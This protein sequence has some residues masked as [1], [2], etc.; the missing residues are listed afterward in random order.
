M[1]SNQTIEMVTSFM[2]LCATISTTGSN[3]PQNYRKDYVTLRNDLISCFG[4]QLP[5]WIRTS[6]T[7][8]SVMAHVKQVKGTGNGSW[9]RRRDYFEEQRMIILEPHVSIQPIAPAS[10]TSKERSA[11]SLHSTTLHSHRHGGT[12]SM[13]TSLADFS[14]VSPRQ[15]DV[16]KMKM[17]QKVFIVHGHNSN[18]KLEVARLIDRA[19]FEAVI[20][21][22]HPNRGRTILQKLIELTDDVV[23]AVILYTACDLGKSVQDEHFQPRARQNVIFEHGFLLAKL[24]QSKVVA[25]REPNVEVPSDL[26]GVLYTSTDDDWRYAL[27][28]ELRE[29]G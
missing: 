27:S 19:G 5:L 4:E 26:S 18:L 15:P 8:E 21:H 20:F 6:P 16:Q 11:R 10:E 23:F 17:R 3:D 24:G 2:S 29:H 12:T 13:P 22:E 14:K 1:D 9:Q 25:L 7:P 28:E